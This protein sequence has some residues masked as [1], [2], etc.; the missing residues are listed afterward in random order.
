MIRNQACI[1]WFYA[2]RSDK[3]LEIV[4]YKQNT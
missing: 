4:L 3:H 2:A 1:Y